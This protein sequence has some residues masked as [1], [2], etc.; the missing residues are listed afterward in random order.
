M[1]SFFTF[2]L[3]LFR[4]IAV[5]TFCAAAPNFLFA[6]NCHVW[7]KVEITLHAEESYENPYKEVEV[8]VELKGPDF[9]KRCYGFWDGDK[10]FRV[11]VMATAPGAW[12]WTSGS[13]QDDPGLNNKT[14]AFTTA[15]WQEARK[16]ENPCRRGMIKPS[17][18]G[19]AF[20]YADGTPFFL[21]G[22]TWWSAGTF[23]YPWHEID[24]PRPIGP[25]AGFKDYVRFRRKQGFNC[26]AMI[27][28][29]PNWANDDKPP[30]FKTSDG[31]Q[32]RSAWP[33][34]GTKSA[35]NMTDQ[36]GNRAFLFPGKVPGYEGYFPDVERINPAY[37]QSLDKKIDYLNANGFLPFIEVARR[38]IGPAWKK[39]Y[40]W[41]E[42][43]TRYIQY[44]W[45]RYQANICL[46]SP[47]HFDSRSSLAA[48][49]WNQA[50][51]RV[52]E[53]YGHPPFGTLAGCNP[54]GSSLKF[55]DHRTNAKWITFHQ[56][57]NSHRHTSYALMTETF[58]A[59][60]PLPGINGEPYYAGMHGSPGGSRQSGLNCR[61]HMYGSVLSGGYGGHIYGAG[62]RAPKGGAM[63]AGEVENIDKPH[64]W[65]AIRWPSGDQMRHLRAFI[66]SEGPKYQ[67][68]EPKV[69]LLSP[70][71][72]Q[73]KGHTGWDGC[74]GWAYCSRTA[75]KDLFLL[76]FEKYCD[77]ATLSG[78]ALNRKYTA[79]W[80]NPRFGEWIN[81]GDG[82]LTADAEGKIALP[83][84]PYD[85]TKSYTDWAL[86][87]TLIEDR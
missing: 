35:K 61:S 63:W 32:L 34:A 62:D 25:E 7:E 22:D 67:Q 58:H 45:T 78:A 9:N 11:R 26:I 16:W 77:K 69:E 2:R 66:L 18:N 71:K 21:L 8:W 84:F 85:L 82:T 12:T 31:T 33:Q 6:D 57:G 50:A 49:H 23:R 73:P 51:N 37:F 53:K 3:S 4:T 81:A 64:I 48:D 10:T 75:D 38:D 28:A 27:A 43:Y 52:I 72:S 74:I 65:D 55:F 30:A 83:N 42:S 60:P 19:H 1:R 59:Q 80:F 41:P 86:K 39:Y 17:A 68:L 47:I 36:K 24:R 14:G 79:R 44:V 5:L 56:I 54:A 40:P 87:L 76:Y 70:N 29:F 15:A 46:F 13:N 20:E